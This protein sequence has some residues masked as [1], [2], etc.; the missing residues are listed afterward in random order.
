MENST[1][2]GVSG[3][4]VWFVQL[5]F[6][7]AIQSRRKSVTRLISV[8]TANSDNKLVVDPECDQRLLPRFLG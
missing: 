3:S 2:S 6:W 4:A 5:V 7:N 8:K 1:Q